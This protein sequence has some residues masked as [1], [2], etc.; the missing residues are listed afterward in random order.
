MLDLAMVYSWR[1]NYEGA[2]QAIKKVYDPK[3]PELAL[4]A[5]ALA[6]FAIIT[7]RHHEIPELLSHMEENNVEGSSWIHFYSLITGDKS[8]EIEAIRFLGI[9]GRNVPE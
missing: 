5:L 9:Y 1:A 3:K 4:E 7:G 6:E 2:Y 8:Q